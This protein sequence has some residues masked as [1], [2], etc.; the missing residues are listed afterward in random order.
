MR[1]TVLYKTGI[2]K[3]QN[4]VW[5]L[6]FIDILKLTDCLFILLDFR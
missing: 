2:H 6:Y 1:E 5:I 3:G 4:T